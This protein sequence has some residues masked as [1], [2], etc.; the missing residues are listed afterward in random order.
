MNERMKESLII[1]LVGGIALM[2]LIVPT[3]VDQL[4]DVNRRGTGSFEEELTSR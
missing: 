3:A 1:G 2:P 4:Y